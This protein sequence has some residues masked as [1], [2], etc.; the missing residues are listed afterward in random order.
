MFSVKVLCITKSVW[1]QE[2]DER[3]LRK[4]TAKR[5]KIGVIINGEEL[6]GDFDD[7]NAG[8]GRNKNRKEGEKERGV[9]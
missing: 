7:E 9:V 8:N 2:N 3:A 5:G 4:K 1:R 6:D